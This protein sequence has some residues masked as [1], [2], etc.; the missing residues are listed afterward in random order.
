MASQRP[1]LSQY[2]FLLAHGAGAGKDSEWMV[3]MAKALNHAGLKTTTFDFPYMQKRALDGKRRPPDRM[4][5]LLD[6][7][8]AEVMQN[9]KAKQKLIIYCIVEFL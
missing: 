2:H 9:R 6:A 8:R 5:K 4:P 1:K 7:Y 3:N